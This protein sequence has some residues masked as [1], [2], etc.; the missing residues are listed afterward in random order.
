MVT[1][2]PSSRPVTYWHTTWQK[3]KLSIE[4]HH[5]RKDAFFHDVIRFVWEPLKPFHRIVCE[6]VTPVEGVSIR[7]PLAAVTKTDASG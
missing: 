2:L 4:A 5:L 6:T 3:G 1:Q 7:M